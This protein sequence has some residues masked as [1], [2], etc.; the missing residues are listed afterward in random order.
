MSQRCHHLAAV[1]LALAAPCAAGAVGPQPA[2]SDAQPAHS[3]AVFRTGV[4]LV[5]IDA[6]VVDSR[7]E[8]D[9]TLGAEDFALKV[10]G[11]PRPV[12]SA[13]FVFAGASRPGIPPAPSHYSS[14]EFV[15]PG[16]LVVIAVDRAHIRRTE[17]RAAL[18]A[19]AGLLDRLDA[20]D[21][22]AVVGLD[23]RGALEFTR[24]RA[25][26]A[27]RLASLAG[28]GDPVLLRFNIGLAEAVEIA[29]GNRARLAD[30]VLR[31]CGR[32]L[33][34]YDNPTRAGDE[35]AGGRDACP[36]QLEQEARAVA[37]HARVQARLSLGALGAIV[38][39]L[40]AFD[41]PST[42]VLLTEGL[43]AD[44]RLVD[45]AQFSL[46]AQ[47]ARVSLYVLQME[48]PLFEASTD[49]VSPTFLHD[50]RLRSDGLE[51]LAGAARG[52]VFR[53]IG[54]DPAP[55]QRIADELAGY[56]LIA[57]EPQEA[58][59]DG[60]LH[61]I[62]L[63]VSGDR[64]VRAR[65]T[66]RLPATTTA[67]RVQQEQ[68]ER[69]LRSTTPRTELPLR[70]TTY[71]SVQPGSEELRV[72][73][74]LEIDPA[75][76]SAST[77]L[78]GYVI[79]DE[80]GVIAASGAERLSSGRHAFSTVATPGRY[81]LRV[82]A[83]DPLGRRGL[84]EHTFVASAVRAGPNLRIGDLVIAPEPPH[85]G[86]PLHPAVDRVEGPAAIGYLELA[87]TPAAAKDP[88]LHVEFAIHEGSREEPRVVVR[89][90]IAR[91]HAGWAT[92]RA[93]LPLT[94]LPPDR[95]VAV[96][97]VL[98]NGRE[99]ARAVRPFTIAGR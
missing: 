54:G 85:P 79:V 4:E 32:S 13:Q 7:G 48:Q 43:L 65:R 37:Q 20:R 41:Q 75:G 24:D 22:V 29:D 2:P 11:R 80:T 99:L 57:F 3:A 34:E 78:V 26:V 91:L 35:T 53:L 58:D 68:L 33:A 42:L 6:V 15:E 46:A 96:A 90:D 21:R 69:L 62:E 94:A 40:K 38:D 56:Y 31:E 97:R 89:G 8:L 70:V 73:I 52:A 39:A 64:T 86:E 25:R 49:R 19:A 59:R 67:A 50:T 74:S 16:R 63:A 95:Y 71:T 93:R 76:G 12:V 27:A 47:Q 5:T 45:L 66:F 14:N 92:A 51:R 87:P 77:A 23:D 44:P 30:A 88:D 82:A 98:A 1:V 60:R 55:F 84:V 18:Q 17:G 72:V 28:Q 61:R 9:R 81:V 36:E 83:V 10:D